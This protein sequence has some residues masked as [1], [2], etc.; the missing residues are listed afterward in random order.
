MRE[1]IVDVWNE[2]S[3]E[4][5]VEKIDLPSPHNFATYFRTSHQAAIV[6]TIKKHYY[7]L[8]FDTVHKLSGFD[9]DIKAIELAFKDDNI[10]KTVYDEQI[11]DRKKV[12]KALREYITNVLPKDVVDTGADAGLHPDLIRVL[13]TYSP[14]FARIGG[15]IN[16]RIDQHPEE[17]LWAMLRLNEVRGKHDMSTINILPFD[18]GFSPKFHAF[19]QYSGIRNSSQSYPLHEKGIPF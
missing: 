6:S 17:H 4:L 9:N 8:L 10:S 15:T 16:D 5:N 18:N 1:D 19:W 7:D 14:E 3:A 11:S 2:Y 12:H 13:S